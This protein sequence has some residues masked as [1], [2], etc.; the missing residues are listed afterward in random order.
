MKRARTLFDLS[1]SLLARQTPDVLR[2][3]GVEACPPSEREA[4]DAAQSKRAAHRAQGKAAQRKGEAFEDVVREALEVATLQRIVAWYGRTNIGVRKIRGEWRPTERGACDWY[5]V[6]TDGRG[7]VV[8]CK[9]GRKVYRDPSFCG[10]HDASVKPHQARQLEAYADAG[11][12]ALLA[13]DVGSGLRWVRWRDATWPCGVLD[14]AGVATF[15]QA[16]E[17]GR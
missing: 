3:L 4:L 6:L 1:P 7:F 14:S 9:R 10:E 15:A 5:G 13:F 16:V 11:A 2:A 8:E 17:D 12:V